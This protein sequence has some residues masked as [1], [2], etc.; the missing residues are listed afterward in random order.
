MTRINCIPP[1]EL[2]PPHLLAEWKEISRVFSLAREP[3]KNE[4]FPSEYT[5]GTGHVKFFYNKL[6]YISKRYH[7]LGIEM[8]KR[9]YTPNLKM[10]RDIIKAA[11][12]KY[13]DEFWQNWTPTP[14]AM[15]LNRERLKERLKK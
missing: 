5:L 8:Q 12:E 10:K 7:E 2:T 11:V 4:I 14:K 9:G 1:H 15:K 13:P 3:K 6:F